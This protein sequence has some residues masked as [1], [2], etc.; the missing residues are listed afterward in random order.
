MEENVAKE[1]D[2]EKCGKYLGQ[3]NLL[4]AKGEYGGEALGL[5]EG[6][7]GFTTFFQRRAVMPKGASFLAHK[8]KGR[9]P[10]EH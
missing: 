3:G 10:A 5:E 7:R 1:R 4:E 6:V 9:I 2:H 8:R